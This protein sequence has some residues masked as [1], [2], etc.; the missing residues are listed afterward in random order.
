MNGTRFVKSFSVVRSN[1]MAPVSAAKNAGRHANPEPFFLAFQIVELR[2]GAPQ[3][4]RAEGN[5]TGH[6][7]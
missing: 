4:A 6:I 3:E 1:K 7:G 2:Q 5:G